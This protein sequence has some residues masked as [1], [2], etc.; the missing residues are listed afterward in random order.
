VVV[1]AMGA[2]AQRC[3]AGVVVVGWWRWGWGQCGGG[4]VVAMRRAVAYTLAPVSMEKRGGFTI[5]SM[6]VAGVRD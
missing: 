4:L 3:V 1:L 5:V 2:D 6:V